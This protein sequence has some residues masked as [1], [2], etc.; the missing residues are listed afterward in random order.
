MPHH[1]QPLKFLMPGWYAIVMGLTGLTLAWHRATPSM[2]GLAD[3]IARQLGGGEGL[4][5][6]VRPVSPGSTTIS[7]ATHTTLAFCSLWS[8]AA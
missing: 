2:G 1:A 6:P 7:S 5:P 3:T 8:C 4:T